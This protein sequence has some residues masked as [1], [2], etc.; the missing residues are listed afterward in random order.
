MTEFSTVEVAEILGVNRMNFYEWTCRKYIQPVR[1]SKRR[2]NAA[3]FNMAGLVAGGIFSKLHKNIRRP[4][5]GK[6][7]RWWQENG[8][9][10]PGEVLYCKVNGNDVTM[11]S[12]FDTHDYWNNSDYVIAIPIGSIRQWIETRIKEIHSN[13]QEGAHPDRN[14]GKAPQDI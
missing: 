3:V 5:A 2:G 4:I 9:A 6:I 12:L 1:E 7:S 14:R 13:G 11:H 10:L 8:Y